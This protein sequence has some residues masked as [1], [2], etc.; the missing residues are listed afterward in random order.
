MNS[1]TYHINKSIAFGGQIAYLWR[2]NVGAEFLAD[3][4][5][6]FKI[7][8]LVISDHPSLSAYMF[9]A[10]LRIPYRLR[11]AVQAVHF[12]RYR[13]HQHERGSDHD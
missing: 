13:R 5:P 9:N 11:R 1:S 7:P 4:A 10:D 6:T 2:S 12:R 8:S 3:F